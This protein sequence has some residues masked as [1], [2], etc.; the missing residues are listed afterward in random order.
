LFQKNLEK[1]DFSV[2]RSKS[3]LPLLAS[4]ANF[5]QLGEKISEITFSG[6]VKR[7]EMTSH[8]I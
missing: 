2:F 3:K 1:D 6:L 4:T 7:V 8:Q 5:S